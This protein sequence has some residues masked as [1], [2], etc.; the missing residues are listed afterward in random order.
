MPRGKLV[1]ITLLLGLVC[2]PLILSAKPNAAEVDS[3]VQKLSS[4]SEKNKAELLNKIAVAYLYIDTKKAHSYAE[5]ALE[6]AISRKDRK[7]EGTAYVAMGSSY[8]LRGEYEACLPLFKQGMLIGKELNDTKLITNSLN[9]LG[10]YYNRM[11]DFK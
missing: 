4:V 11:G 9:S 1:Y 7:E 8:F 5:Q 10:S 3:L 2:I 6:L